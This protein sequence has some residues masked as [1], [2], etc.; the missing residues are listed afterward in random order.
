MG[1]EIRS[2]F[3]VRLSLFVAI[4]VALGFGVER[5]GG[6][7]GSAGAIYEV[8]TD[9]SH[10]LVITHRSGLFSFLGH[11]HAILATDLV[12]SACVEPDALTRSRIVVSIPTSSLRIDTDSARTLAGLGQ[13]PSANDVV[14]LQGKLLDAQ[15]LAADEFPEIVLDSVKLEQSGRGNLVARGQIKIRGVVQDLVFPVR[16]E[17]REG[18]ALRLSGSFRIRQSVFGIEPERVALVVRVADEVE[19]RFDLSMERTGAKC[20]AA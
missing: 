3:S 4:T 14:S 17:D 7:T 18:S 10:V 19:I 1:G 12:L 9:Q 2:W 16:V 6:Q 15:H 11:E 5:A 8:V 20:D 13:G